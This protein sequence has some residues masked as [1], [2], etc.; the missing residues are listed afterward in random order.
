LLR[1]SSVNALTVF[2]EPTSEFDQPAL[3]SV[4]VEPSCLSRSHHDAQRL[5]RSSKRIGTA[6]QYRTVGFHSSLSKESGYTF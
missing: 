2:V 3:G 1:I 4:A 5:W 6:D